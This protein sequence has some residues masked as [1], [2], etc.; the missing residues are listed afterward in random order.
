MCSLIEYGSNYSETT[1]SS[2]FCSK[3]EANYFNAKDI[4]SANYFKSS[5]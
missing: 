3:D 5:K 4:A 2:W 1:G